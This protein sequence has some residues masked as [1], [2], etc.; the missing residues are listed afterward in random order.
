MDHPPTCSV[1]G[2]EPETSY[3]AMMRCTKARALWECLRQDWS[4]PKEEVLRYT[5]E[6]WVLVLLSQVDEHMRAKLLLLWWRCWHLRNNMIFGDSKARIV[7]SS[8]FLQSYLAS[9]Q[10]TRDIELIID[11]K[12]KCTI[13]KHASNNKQICK[14][15][16]VPWR[17]LAT[18]WAKLNFDASFKEAEGTGSWGAVL[19][20]EHG[21][22]LL[23][24]WGWIPYC[25]NAETAEAIAGLEGI[26]EI[27]PHY[28]GPIHLENDCASLISE[29]CGVG[30]SKSAIA[31]IV[32]GTKSL[33]GSM[34][35]GIFSKV[36]RASNQVAHGLAKLGREEVAGHVLVGAVPPCV[37]ELANYDC[38]TSYVY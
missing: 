37:V 2:M 8:I 35:D 22:V 5:G 31:D 16:I 1:C 30:P 6:D 11:T 20:D 17:R 13:G 12:G 38:K 19:R 26:K 29:L 23:S 3:H 27:F 36:N 14:E 18:G 10:D 4:L 33:L 15:V 28:A 32:K 7:Q 34:S 9:V 24:A 21:E 25:P